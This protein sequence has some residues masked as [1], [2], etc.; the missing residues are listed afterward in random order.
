[1][2]TVTFIN[3]FTLYLTDILHTEELTSRFKKRAPY[4]GVCGLIAD[5]RHLC[6]SS[7]DPPK[8]RQNATKPGMNDYT[9]HYAT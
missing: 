1:M 2:L 5:G 9:L 4:I 7:R 3:Y 6:R 8:K